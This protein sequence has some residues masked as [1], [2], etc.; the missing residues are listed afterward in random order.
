M[1][2]VVAVVLLWAIAIITTVALVPDRQ[3]FTTLGPVY[4]VCMIGSVVVVRKA[5]A[6]SRGA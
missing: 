4:A 1:R 3:V 5:L 2:P 6:P